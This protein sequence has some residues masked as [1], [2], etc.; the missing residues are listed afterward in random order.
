M[1]A[2]RRAYAQH[3]CAP[4]KGTHPAQTTVVPPLR[5]GESAPA[6]GAVHPHRVRDGND[7]EVQRRRGAV[8]VVPPHEQ[9]GRAV[10]VVAA[11]A[12]APPG[13]PPTAAASRVG[14]LPL[15]MGAVAVQPHYRVGGETEPVHVPADAAATPGDPADGGGGGGALPSG[16]L[17]GVVDVKLPP[18]G[19]VGHLLPPLG[20]GG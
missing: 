9:G 11:I 2:S 17:G 5:V 3:V 7:H 6:S 13:S 14:I 10:A 19:R 8:G 16:D 4:H 15:G 18:G 12:V 1:I 20:E